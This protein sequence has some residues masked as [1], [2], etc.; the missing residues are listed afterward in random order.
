MGSNGLQWA[1]MGENGKNT[2]AIVG[3]WLGYLYGK[4]VQIIGLKVQGNYSDQFWSNKI[5]VLVCEGPKLNMSMISG[6]LDPWDP[7]FMDLNIPKDFK[8]YQEN[9]GE[10]LEILFL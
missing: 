4:Y 6:F 1:P 2:Y 10:P 9:M 8:K 5:L 3:N 7:S